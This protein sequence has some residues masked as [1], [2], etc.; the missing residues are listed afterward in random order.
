MGSKKDKE[1]RRMTV[2]YHSA[3]AIEEAAKPVAKKRRGKALRYVPSSNHEMNELM[4]NL[5]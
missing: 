4:K 2:I 1:E 3:K 5:A